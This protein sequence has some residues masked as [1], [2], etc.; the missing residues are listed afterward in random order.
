MANY[1]IQMEYFNGTNYDTLYPTT[2]LSNTTGTLPINN[3]GTGQTTA[4][5]ALYSLISGCST[6]SSLSSSYYFPLQ[7]GSSARRI[8]VSNL[9]NYIENNMENSGGSIKPIVNTIYVGTGND[10]TIAWLP[11]T[12]STDINNICFCIIVAASDFVDERAGIASINGSG[13]HE[14]I[15]NDGFSFFTALR[16]DND[17]RWTFI[18]RG[19]GVKTSS[20][21]VVPAELCLSGRSYTILVL[22]TT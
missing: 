13:Y 21:F 7:Y 4:A 8:T 15:S 2:N 6:T 3:G 22:C 1:N 5:N 20:G 12:T 16:N 14:T 10:S 11:G 19:S 9:L 17:L 18:M